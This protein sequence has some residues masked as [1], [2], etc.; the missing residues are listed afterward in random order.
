VHDFWLSL[1]LNFY[2][3]NAWI[4]IYFVVEIFLKCA[5]N[6][7][8]PC[9]WLFSLIIWLFSLIIWLFLWLSDFFLWYL[10]FSLISDFFLWYLTFF[11]DYLTFFSDYLTF[12]SDY[13]TFHNLNEFRKTKKLSMR[14]LQTWFW[15]SFKVGKS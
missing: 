10:T 11:S 13:L 8:T 14:W 1:C 6:F 4:F 15:F 9:I 12:F 2:F 3:I 7:E 5:N